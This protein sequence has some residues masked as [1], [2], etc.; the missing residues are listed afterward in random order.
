MKILY[1][2][3]YGYGTTS[4]MRGEV[5]KDILN[6]KDF[7]VTDTRVPY[8]MLHPFLR[9]IGFRFKKGPLIS[10]INN[11]IVDEVSRIDGRLDLVWVDKGIF[12]KPEIIK[13]LKGKSDKI[14]HFTPDMA[15]FD[16]R[17]KKF[18]RSLHLY[19]YVITTKEPEVNFYKEYISD[20]KIVLSTQGYSRSIHHP[21][22]SF[23]EK[24]YDI[25]FVGLYEKHRAEILQVLIDNGYSIAFA[26][27]GW[28]EFMSRNANNPRVHYKGKGLFGENYAKLISEC[29]FGLGLLSKKFPE[30][31]TTR[32]FEI[33]ACGT[34]LITE[35]TEQTEKYF[36]SDEVLFYSEA[37][38][39]LEQLSYYLSAPPRLIELTKK[40]A[41][42]VVKD[43][44]DYESV[45]KEILKKIG[46]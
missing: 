6:P 7:I 42:R 26:G 46:Y 19:D 22:N 25:G 35:S 8:F 41:E 20:E 14:I 43:Q 21:Y 16:N 12:I 30:L 32:T 1:I 45:M 33:P 4:R 17:S 5:L 24:K 27:N 29:K 38:D 2:G 15:F 13:L 23:E 11:F 34:A 28:T 9:S 36:E 44:R 3:Q 39:L 37:K 40:G 10:K 18:Y 31:H